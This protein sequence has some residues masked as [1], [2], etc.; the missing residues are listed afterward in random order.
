M[1][2]TFRTVS[3]PL[4]FVA[5]LGRARHDTA[6]APPVERVLRRLAH[7]LS[8][9]IWLPLHF[10]LRVIARAAT[11][12][13]PPSAEVL[14]ERFHLATRLVERSARIL[15]LRSTPMTVCVAPPAPVETAHEPPS[16]RVVMIQR[17]ERQTFF[18][19]ITQV[20][21]R[22]AQPAARP[23]P[24]ST[25]S[26]LQVAE[27]RIAQLSSATAA[28]TAFAAAPLPAAEL[29]RVTDHVIRQLDQR[30]LSYRERTGRI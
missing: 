28:S 26:A 1:R 15:Q 17:V 14:R 22:A 3:D 24:A 23:Q 8:Q 29:T 21:A 25:E 6:H 13:E 2:R 16:A 4:A 27:H 10:A 7:S 12:S 9:R 19:R 30:V 18:P 11:P 20:L 5:T